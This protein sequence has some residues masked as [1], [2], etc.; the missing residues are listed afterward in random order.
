[1]EEHKVLQAKLVKTHL[2]FDCNIRERLQA[3]S[4]TARAGGKFAV[5]I[6]VTKVAG[7]NPVYHSPQKPWFPF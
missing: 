1:M 5:N 6:M 4:V 3:F 2:T 7:S